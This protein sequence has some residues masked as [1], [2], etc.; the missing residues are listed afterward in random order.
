MRKL[1]VGGIVYVAV[2]VAWWLYL[3]Y[4]TKQFRES[5]PRPPVSSTVSEQQTPAAPMSVEYLTAG[6][7]ENV[8]ENAEAPTA[9][10][11]TDDT[12]SRVGA[13]AD[14]V[15][16]G[17]P[18]HTLPEPVDTGLSPELEAL[19]TAYEARDREFEEVGRVLNRLLYRHVKA[20]LRMI[21][22]GSE[23]LPD[24]IDGP[25]R[26][27]LYAELEELVAWK[28]SVNKEIFELQDESN[29]LIQERSTV[30][31]EYGISSWQ[32]FERR[33]G[34]TYTAWRSNR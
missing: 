26:K 16:E 17:E 7:N 27:A 24:S 21:E 20:T 25:E 1:I 29:R 30:L 3:E 11:A 4:D 5:L 23:A 14:T 18:I 9:P 22:L 32:E 12:L 8:S 33:H 6:K 10:I 34:E 19:F 2:L 31:A 28:Q 13:A 15:F